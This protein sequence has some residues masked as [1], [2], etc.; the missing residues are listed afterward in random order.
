MSRATNPQAKGLEDLPEMHRP[1]QGSRWIGGG[2]LNSQDRCRRSNGTL[3]AWF[4]TRAEA[5]AFAENPM[6]TAY[7]GDTP[8]PCL[9]PGCDDLHLSQRYWPDARAAAIAWVN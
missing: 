5:I 7:H 3:Q 8:V 6:N 9:K 4:A 1:S 2:T